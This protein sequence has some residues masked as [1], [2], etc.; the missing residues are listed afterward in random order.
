VLA[1]GLR[2]KDIAQGSDK[3]IGTQEMGAAILSELK[4]AA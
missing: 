2:T 1:K 3:S 4:A